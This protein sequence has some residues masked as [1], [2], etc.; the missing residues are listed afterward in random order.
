MSESRQLTVYFDGT[1][2]NKDQ[3]TP[4]GT[5]TNVAR[6][7]ERWPQVSRYSSI[8]PRR[9]WLCNDIEQGPASRRRH[10]E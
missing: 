5:Q 4:E 1:G 8:H 10:G 9:L 7:Y 3:A 2:N 6:L